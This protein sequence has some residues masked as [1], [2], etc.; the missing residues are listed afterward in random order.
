MDN[1]NVDDLKKELQDFYRIC[2]SGWYVIKDQEGEK[3]MGEYLSPQSIAVKKPEGV[4]P[5][6]VIA[7]MA[8]RY[9]KL[10]RQRILALEPGAR[11]AA[12]FQII[13]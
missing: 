12:G 1:E 13:P 3:L 8:E 6:G 4:V 10:L 9:G 7:K 11:D 2:P 5:M